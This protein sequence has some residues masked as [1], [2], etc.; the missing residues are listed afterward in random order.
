MPGK[1]GAGAWVAVLTV[2][3][4]WVT[5][6]D[7][8]WGLSVGGN[9]VVAVAVGV[10]D[11]VTDGSGVADGSGVT[12]VAGSRTIPGER[13]ESL[14]TVITEKAIAARRKS[15]RAPATTTPADC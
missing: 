12:D 2:E 7:A 15:P 6:G 9:G 11:V 1:P 4:V 8:G 13:V 10:E 3:A 5:V 14:D